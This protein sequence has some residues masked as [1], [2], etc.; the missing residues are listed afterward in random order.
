MGFLYPTEEL[1]TYGYQTQTNVKGCTSAVGHN[2]ERR[3]HSSVFQTLSQDLGGSGENPPMLR[4]L[5]HSRT[6][7]T[8]AAG[9]AALQCVD[10]CLCCANQVSNPFTT[11]RALRSRST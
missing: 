10:E 11:S 7:V 2:G 6:L 9:L 8:D 3:Q 4:A 1:K 5:C